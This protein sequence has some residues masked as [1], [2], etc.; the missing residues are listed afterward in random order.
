MWAVFLGEREVEGFLDKNAGHANPLRPD[1]TAYRDVGCFYLGELKALEESSAQLAESKNLGDL[2]LVVLSA[3]KS[4]DVEALQSIGLP[5]D[6][7]IDE[8]QPIWLALQDELAALST[9]STHVIAEGSGHAI[10][11]DRPDL[12][13]ATIRQVLSQVAP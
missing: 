6:F 3:E 10:H 4:I 8:I 2:P 9:N 1:R 13:I 12:V 7:P 11:L 5:G